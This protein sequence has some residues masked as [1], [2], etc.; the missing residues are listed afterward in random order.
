MELIETTL[1]EVRT[2]ALVRIS[3]AIETATTLDE[4]LLLALNELTQLFQVASGGV[5][6]LND[7]GSV[8]P[9]ASE[10][11]PQVVPSDSL[12]IA[13][14]PAIRRAIRRRQTV[15]VNDTDRDDRRQQAWQNLRMRGIR[16]L[17]LVP[18]I[19]HDRPIGRTA[20]SPTRS[21][22]HACCQASSLLRS[23]PSGS[24]KRLNAA[25]KNSKPSTISRPL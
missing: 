7:D 3:Q 18:L 12:S 1:S 21:R 10:Y 17:L 19:V 24:T 2:D 16:S 23:R 9:L 6:L 15:Q 22:W 13:A 20:S 5:V 8:S 14:A 4:L 11:P 25:T